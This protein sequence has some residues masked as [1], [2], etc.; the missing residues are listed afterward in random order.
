MADP[1]GRRRRVPPY[2]SR[3]FRFEIQ[4]FR[5]V[6]VSGVGAPPTGNPGSATAYVSLKLSDS[7]CDCDIAKMSTIDFCGTI[8]IKQHQNQRKCDMAI[9]IAIVQCE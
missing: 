3:F 7:I 5:N 9:A 4:I 6:A 8:H 2:G 1:G